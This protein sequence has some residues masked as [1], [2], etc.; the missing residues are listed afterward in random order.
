[1]TW[2]SRLGCVACLAACCLSRSLPAALVLAGF[3]VA[4]GL[5]GEFTRSDFCL[6]SHTIDVH[7]HY[8]GT[9]CSITGCGCQAF[10]RPWVRRT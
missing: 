2:L 10:S 8:R 6:C 4:I 7:K 1:M 9:H 5:A 3:A